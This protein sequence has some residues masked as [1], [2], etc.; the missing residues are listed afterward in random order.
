MNLLL[1]LRAPDGES[2]LLLTSQRVGKLKAGQSRTVELAAV[3]SRR[4]PIRRQHPGRLSRQAGQRRRLRRLAPDDAASRPH[5]GR[6]ADLARRP[7]VRIS[8]DRDDL[9]HPD[10]HGHQ[11]GETSS[12]PIAT[13]IT[14][15]DPGQFTKSAD[16]CDGQALA[17]G[18]SCDGR[19]RVRPYLDRRQ[20]RRAASVDRRVERD[21][22]LTGTGIAPGQP[23]DLARRPHGFGTHATGTTSGAQTFTVTNTGG[24]PSGTIATSV[25]G[26][27]AGQFTKSADN[28]NGQ[29]LGAGRELHGRR[30]LRADLGRRQ[31]REPS[32]VGDARRAAHRRRSPAPGADPGQ[33]DDLADPH[34]FGTHAT[35]T[36]S[37]A[38]TFTVTNTGGVPAG[39]SHRGGRRRPGQFTKSADNCNGQT[40]AP[41]ASCTVD[42]A[43][44]PTSVGAKA[45]S[46]EA[47]ATPG[48]TASAA[49][50]GTGQTPANLTISPSPQGFGT[51]ATGTTSPA[52][53][54]TV[55]NTG[56]VPSGTVATSLIGADPGQFT[57]SADTCN[58]QTLAP[59]ASCT[60]DGAFAPTSVGAK[61][62]TFTRPRRRAARLG[63]PQR[64]GRNAGQPDDLAEPARLRQPRQQHDLAG[65]D[66]HGH[67]Y[68]WRAERAR[69]R[70]R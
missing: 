50:T 55:T 6:S 34:G 61:A 11:P 12:Q 43:F 39:R 13:S 38:Q 67:E 52:Q 33:P 32:G 70:Q 22:A 37:P 5:P 19:R 8:R 35:G 17:P 57:K 65:A 60:V 7:H 4:R 31:G 54:F 42:G 28:C 25:T 58:G 41:G 1:K 30:R 29:T 27:D 16:S 63:V 10:V 62:A 51:H 53:T 15:A 48:G 64:H 59:G 26:A 21:P 69:S 36:T 18:E 49:L 23:D 20:V 56:G 47:S 40:L 3:D 68:R 66:V 14:G 46:L 24:A 45:A 2:G 44:A 9:P